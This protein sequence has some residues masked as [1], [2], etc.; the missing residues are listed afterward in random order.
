MKP[1]GLV[2]PLAFVSLSVLLM[3]SIMF[4]DWQRQYQQQYQQQQQQ[5][6]QQQHQQNYHS[7]L[8]GD[9]EVHGFFGI[10]SNDG[11][12]TKQAWDIGTGG[13]RGSEARSIAPDAQ[14]KMYVS[15]CAL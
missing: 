7:W 14:D 8:P 9:D 5:Q 12:A 4:F 6:Q 1:F 3:T 15:D 13:D 2:F 10:A 11:A